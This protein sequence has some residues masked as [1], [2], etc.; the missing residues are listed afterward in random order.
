MIQRSGVFAKA[1]PHEAAMVGVNV[2]S[3][4]IIWTDTKTT[5][6]YSQHLTPDISDLLRI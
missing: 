3:R 5:S 2:A 4:Y 6:A 1:G